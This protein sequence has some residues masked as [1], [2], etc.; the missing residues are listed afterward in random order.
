MSPEALL[1]MNEA[2]MY[3]ISGEKSR[4]KSPEKNRD[5]NLKAR[6]KSRKKKSSTKF[7]WHFLG[8][9]LKGFKDKICPL[10][11]VKSAM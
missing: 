4:E 10:V 6:K 8:S 9:V 3:V 1:S 11:K 2:S 7:A 5:K